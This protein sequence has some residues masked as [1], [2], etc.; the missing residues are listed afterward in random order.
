MRRAR[1][2]WGLGCSRLTVDLAGAD[3]PLPPCA[4]FSRE[5]IV[6]GAAGPVPLS[7]ALIACGYEALAAR[8]A[9]SKLTIAGLVAD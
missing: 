6:A 3:A 7:A 2:T 8:S 1:S 4:S 5:I 9:F